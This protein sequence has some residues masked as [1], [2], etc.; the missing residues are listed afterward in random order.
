MNFFLVVIQYMDVRS[1]LRV[2]GGGGSKPT[3][4]VLPPSILTK[5]WA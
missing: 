2:E 4:M 1:K 5:K 3:K